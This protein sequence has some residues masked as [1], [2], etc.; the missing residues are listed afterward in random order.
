MDTDAIIEAF[1]GPKQ[2]G[3]AIGISRTH[4]GAMKTRGSIPPEYWERIVEAAG[5]RGIKDVTLAAL[6]RNAARNAERRRPSS[7][8]TVPAEDA[9]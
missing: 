3:D 4:A 7:E 6:A 9:A 8:S 1:G 2:F 5:A